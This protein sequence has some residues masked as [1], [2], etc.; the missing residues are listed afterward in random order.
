MCFYFGQVYY[1]LPSQMVSY[2]FVFKP[3]QFE[4]RWYDVVPTS[5]TMDQDRI[6]IG[7]SFSYLYTDSLLIFQ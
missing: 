3:L 4:T 6:N 2:H 5:Q 1:L 7:I